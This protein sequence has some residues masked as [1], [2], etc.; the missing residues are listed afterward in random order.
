V[1][2][3]HAAKRRR[4]GKCVA[5]GQGVDDPRKNVCKRQE[6]IDQRKLRKQKATADLGTKQQSLR[7]VRP[8]SEKL[9]QPKVI[10]EAETSG[11]TKIKKSEDDID[12]D[13][14]SDQADRVKRAVVV[15]KKD[16]PKQPAYLKSVVHDVVTDPFAPSG[17]DADGKPLRPER[18]G[19]DI[20]KDLMSRPS[21]ETGATE[22]GPC[23]CNQPLCRQC[24]P[25]NTAKTTV[26]ADLTHRTP[27]P[28]P[29][30]EDT[31]R[32]FLGV[33]APRSTQLTGKSDRPQ[34]GRSFVYLPAVFEYNREQMIALFERPV[35]TEL[36]LVGRDKVL[37]P[38]AEIKQRIAE[39]EA[40]L[41]QK[42]QRIIEIK[43][44]IK[45]EEEV[46]HSMSAS[47]QK[48]R[49]PE[50]VLSQRV[51]EAYK[52]E[53]KKNIESY[54]KEKRQLE[55]DLRMSNIQVLYDRMSNW[56]SNPDDYETKPKWGRQT[57][58]FHEKFRLPRLEFKNPLSL[59]SGYTYDYDVFD[60]T[61]NE[62]GIAAYVQQVYLYSELD[63]RNVVWREW[64]WFENSVI[65]QAIEWGLIEPNEQI[66]EQYELPA[67][68]SALVK[69]QHEQRGY[70]DDS[71][72][73]NAEIIRT[74]GASIGGNIR[75][76]GYGREL[77]TFDK[78]KWG[79]SSGPTGE[80]P[81]NFY[82]GVDSG[83]VGERSGDE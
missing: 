80:G 20:L 12:T 76:E 7:D 43:A 19:T 13:D 64:E 66:A 61:D 81:D 23:Q 37:K 33:P 38:I 17:R 78:E 15:V 54:K 10:T 16:R 53:A 28:P 48:L 5:C 26:L 44:L 32:K 45:E 72:A 82:G 11:G 59:P 9:P 14:L 52:R 73:E 25:G 70:A 68:R 22:E 77:Y 18:S 30:L 65:C 71:D 41:E 39:R 63:H 24:H 46:I 2:R 4:S 1:C 51:R 31:V 6:C 47:V 40:E 29:S 3:E 62:A 21:V 57:I 69:Q 49:R 42:K 8:T 36:R 50:D 27:P 56:G 74:G 34:P 83:D 60:P 79:Y 67:F 35:T 75:S 55:T 58:L